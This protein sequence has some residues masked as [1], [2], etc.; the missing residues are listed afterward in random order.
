ML[1]A[2]AV[3][4]YKKLCE[5]REEREP[6]EF[7]ASDG[8]LWRFSRR[9]GI[10][11]LALQGEKLSADAPAAENFITSFRT[12]IED[13]HYTLHQIFNSDESGLYYKLLPEKTLASHFEKTAD[14]RKKQKER[15]TINACSNAS[16]SIKLPLLL[17]GKYKKPRCFKHISHDSLPVVYDNQSNAW[18]DAAIFA[19][20]FHRHF[21]PTV[22]KELKEMGLDQR[23][24]LVL[25][26][27]SA[28]P[29]EDEL[30]SDD[31]KIIAKFLPPNVT[32]LIQPM[33]QG[34]LECIKRHY[35]RKLLEELVLKDEEGISIL[36]FLKSIDML[37]VTTLV[38]ASWDEITAQTLQRSWRKILSEGEG[39]ATGGDESN[40][41][42]TLPSGESG[43]VGEFHSMF[44]TI[45][46]DL[47]EEEIRVWLASD[48]SDPGYTHFSDEDIVSNIIK[49]STHVQR[50]ESEESEDEDSLESTPTISH[51]A[52]VKSFDE[53]LQ[54]LQAQ[55]EATMYNISVLQELRD[56]ARRKHSNALK[57]RKLSDF[58]SHTMS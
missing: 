31:K 54:W 36:T 55:Q 21:V 11:Q 15:V 29:S 49:E 28:H 4:L 32:S 1:Q 23:A 35:K 3:H 17:I 14:G 25:D 46:H 6:V 44:H 22:R 53:S 13:Q 33:D 16:G 45:G 26:N 51:L 7:V 56:L 40:C 2:K 27:C 52:A 20:W 24:V 41:P 9:H 12:F 43:G 47:S 57:Q 50:E 42:E 10:R 18:V 48:R 37:R 38:A 58:M 30:V 8:W 39:C 19:N 5:A 34:V